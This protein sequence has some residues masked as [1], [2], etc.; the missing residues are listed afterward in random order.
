MNWL[1]LFT[2]Q[3]AEGF[4]DPDPEVR[5]ATLRAVTPIAASGNK[6]PMPRQRFLQNT[7]LDFFAL[8]LLDKDERLRE[9]AV[10]RLVIYVEI[11]ERHPSSRLT[12]LRPYESRLIPNLM[13]AARD[14]SPKV[15][16]RASAGLRTILRIEIDDAFAKLGW[17]G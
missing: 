5:L 13:L 17:K 14:P 4:S 3:I 15:R 2:R 6:I 10:D 1:E 12:F 16:E 9:A 7:L 11:V 8:S